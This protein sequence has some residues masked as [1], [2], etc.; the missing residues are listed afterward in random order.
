M[1]M[2]IMSTT[3]NIV[4]IGVLRFDCCCY[5]CGYDL[6]LVVVLMLSVPQDVPSR[7]RIWR[8]RTLWIG[9]WRWDQTAVDH[10]FFPDSFTKKLASDT[11]VQCS[12]RKKSVACFLILTISSEQKNVKQSRQVRISILFTKLR[13]ENTR[14]YS[15]FCVFVKIV[16]SSYKIS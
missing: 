7:L 2:N 11:L 9:V 14:N 8:C 10:V 3:G 12:N 1:T 16:H 15:A 13:N 6:L 5:Y 4:H